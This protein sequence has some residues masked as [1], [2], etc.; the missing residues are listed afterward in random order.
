MIL[1]LLIY[2]G[3]HTGVIV[4]EPVVINALAVGSLAEKSASYYEGRQDGAEEGKLHI[5]P[6]R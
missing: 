5:L 4:A 6:Y 3:A 2:L 1:A